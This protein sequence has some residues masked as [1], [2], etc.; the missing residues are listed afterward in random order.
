MSDFSNANETTAPVVNDDGFIDISG[1]GGLL[2]KILAEGSGGSPEEG[3]MVKAHYTG[4][5]EDGSE[6][7]SSRSRNKVFEFQIGKGQVIK[8][9]DLGFASMKKG[10]KAILRI[11]GDY[12]YGKRGSP[13][14]IP[15]NATLNFDVELIDF[16]EKEKEK[17]EMSDDEKIA[18]A[19]AAKE[20]G[21]ALFKEK[22]F[23][24]ALSSYEMAAD[25]IS[26]IDSVEQ[27]WCVC[28]LN[29]AQCH[30][31]L[32]NYPSAAEAATAALEKDSKNVKALFRRA[33]ARNAMGLPEEA[34][35]D[36]KE[37][38]SLDPEN[39]A[40]KAE[41]V[42]SKKAITD[43]K[44]KEK[45]AFGGMFSKIS[46]YG[47]CNNCNTTITTVNVI[48]NKITYLYL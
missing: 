26:D 25:W 20:A 34:L 36:L 8:G 12:A 30:L 42:K 37:A 45:A 5:L 24:G 2:K 11:R 14:K 31:N 10:E 21:T 33:C 41:M 19:E 4:T 28:K 29:S 13:P 16:H 15:P 23:T 3:N 43:A 46:M 1:D 35:T 6:F 22:D 9:W 27:T 44:K 7:D 17:W 48:T 38:L 18:K 40:V 32:K 47:K 39:A